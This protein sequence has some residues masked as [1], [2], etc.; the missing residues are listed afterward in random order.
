MTRFR[1][2]AG[3]A[4][5]GLLAL[6]LTGAPAHAVRVPAARGEH[7]RRA[8]TSFVSSAELYDGASG[9][10]LDKVEQSLDA[11]TMDRGIIIVQRPLRSVPASIA[12]A[13]GGVNVAADILRGGIDTRAGTRCAGRAS[14]ASAVSGSSRAR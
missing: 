6:L 9:P 2:G 13:W 8:L 3:A 1:R 11:G 7:L 14:P 4:V 5:V 10:G 12:R